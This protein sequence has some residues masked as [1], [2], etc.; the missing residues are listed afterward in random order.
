M[1]NFSSISALVCLSNFYIITS[2]LL[3]FLISL[4]VLHFILFLRQ[5]R[6]PSLINALRVFIVHSILFLPDRFLP[7]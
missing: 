4:Q 1:A 6:F 7:F 2:L 5:V 3:I